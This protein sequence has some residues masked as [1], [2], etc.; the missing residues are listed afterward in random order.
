[1]WF[2]RFEYII[3]D[4]KDERRFG[5]PPFRYQWSIVLPNSLPSSRICPQHSKIRQPF[6]RI[7]PTLNT[8]K[9]EKDPHEIGSHFYEN[10]P[11]TGW[12]ASSSKTPEKT[13]RGH[14]ENRSS[15][16]AS[17]GIVHPELGCKI[18]GS[19][20]NEDDYTSNIHTGSFMKTY[21]L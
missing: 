14:H 15:L 13:F 5:I 8:E 6:Q 21:P 7:L 16:H 12:R 19:G 3:F 10:P 17:A 1:M 2:N 4:K 9:D 11:I 18:H 20:S